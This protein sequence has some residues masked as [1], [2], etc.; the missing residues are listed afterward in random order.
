M[1]VLL[2]IGVAL[3]A[4]SGG[5]EIEVVDI[6]AEWGGSVIVTLF[7]QNG[8]P[9]AGQA[10]ISQNVPVR[11]IKAT[12]TFESIPLGEYA[13]AV[14]QDVNGNGQLN[15]TIYGQPTEPYAFSNNVFGRFGPP[16]FTAAAFSVE[17]N[18]T[19]KLVIQLKE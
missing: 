14:Y 5:V 7:E 12:V 8:F 1:I 2:V 11:D 3:S 17:G 18:G 19:V 9:K 15:R 6:V 13:I 16:K 4:Q 10:I